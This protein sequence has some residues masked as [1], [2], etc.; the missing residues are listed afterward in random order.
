MRRAHQRALVLLCALAATW[1]FAHHALFG[2]YGIE[3][4]QILT[5]RMIIARGKLAGLDAVRVDLAR[6][7]ALLAT[8]P[9]HPDLV[10][11]LARANLGFAR[12]TD[13]LLVAAP[14]MASR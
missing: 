13:R 1:H 6:D 10:E 4:R 12:H 5:E 9:P 8:E 3:T 7:V 14:V 11:E 2:R